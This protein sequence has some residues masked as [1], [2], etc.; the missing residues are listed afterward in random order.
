M[1]VYLCTYKHI[2]CVCVC[3]PKTSIRCCSL[4][5]PSCWGWAGV[6][7]LDRK[8]YTLPG[9]PHSPNDL[10]V[11]SSSLMSTHQFFAWASPAFP[12]DFVFKLP[13]LD[14]GHPKMANEY[15][16]LSLRNHMFFSKNKATFKE[17][18]RKEKEREV[19]RGT[20]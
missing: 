16:I 10:W 13:V 1:C 2:M 4:A 18:E 8:D 19:G 6:P 12:S 20:G 15:G 17:D 7:S 3:V 11:A 5:N 9:Q 14:T